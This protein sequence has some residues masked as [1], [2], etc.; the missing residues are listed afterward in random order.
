ML[1][2]TRRAGDR[3][4]LQVGDME[5]TITT[6]TIKGQQVRV[7]IDAPACVNIVREEVLEK[8]NLKAQENDNEGY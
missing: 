6:L 1:I 5:I 4:F 3:F 2:L 7:G 8:E